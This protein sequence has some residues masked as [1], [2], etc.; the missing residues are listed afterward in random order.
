M[1]DYST[2]NQSLAGFSWIFTEF[3][4]RQSQQLAELRMKE[5]ADRPDSPQ[6]GNNSEQVCIASITY[7]FYPV[8]AKNEGRS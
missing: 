6:S 1:L 8:I 2:Q 7:S 3:L 4:K 5:S